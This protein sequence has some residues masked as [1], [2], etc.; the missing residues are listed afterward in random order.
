MITQ[1]DEIELS[2]QTFSRWL[3]RNNREQI[4]W[5]ARYLNENKT[6][7]RLLLKQVEG[8]LE[9][10]GHQVVVAEKYDALVLR[11]AELDVLCGREGAKLTARIKS[12]WSQHK[13]RTKL[14]LTDYKNINMV[15]SMRAINNLK[16]LSESIN[17]PQNK[18]IED[19][20]EEKL[21]LLLNTGQIHQPPPQHRELQV[22]VPDLASTT[23]PA[24][25]LPGE[26]LHESEASHDNAITP[27]KISSV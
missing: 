9:G 16:K 26:D 21:E 19:L 10:S 4:S 27:G 12:A 7:Q 18:V 22:S 24:T 5:L 25:P 13:Y 15:L 8:M 17:K 3:A 1:N 11:M 2:R 6:A 20:I 23:P 14:R